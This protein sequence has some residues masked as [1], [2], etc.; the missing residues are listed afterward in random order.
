MTKVDIAFFI[1]KLSIGGIEKNTLNIAK[2][3]SAQGTKVDLVLCD[4]TGELVKQVPPEIKIHYLGKKMGNGKLALSTLPLSSYLRKAKP[5]VLFSVSTQ[6]NLVA[7]IA[8]KLAGSPATHIISE[9]SFLSKR[10]Q[11]RSYLYRYFIKNSVRILYPLADKIHTVSQG[12][13]GDLS[14]YLKNAQHT[15]LINIPHPL[16]CDEIQKLSEIEIDKRDLPAIKPGLLIAAVGRLT[17]AKDYPTM[18]NAFHSFLLNNPASLLIV[19]DGSLRPDL[20]EKAKELG[21]H[22]NVHFLGHKDNPYQYIKLAD[23]F[24]LSSQWEGLPTV[25]LEAL[26]LGKYVI[27]TDCM[28]G[29]REILIDEKL[30]YLTPTNDA[31]SFSQAMQQ[32][33]ANGH[34][35]KNNEYRINYARN[36]FD[37]SL[38]LNRYRLELFGC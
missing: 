6:A 4:K 30:G 36:N 28:S 2:L 22:D 15:P 5:K 21:I 1:P 38:I 23:F 14:S 24:L 12:V 32:A 33:V 18:L 31:D 20:E 16:V 26:C 11:K 9:R 25:I 34:P 29:P 10:L 3:L 7:L 19:G 37:Q 27:S 35:W 17:A 13:A 8:N